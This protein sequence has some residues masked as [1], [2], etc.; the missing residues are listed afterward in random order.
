[1]TEVAHHATANTRGPN[2][3][4][5]ITPNPGKLVLTGNPSV[6]VTIYVQPVVVSGVKHTGFSTDQTT[7]YYGG[8][9]WQ[10]GPEYAMFMTFQYSTGIGEIT[11]AQPYAL[12]SGTPTLQ[13]MCL[14]PVAEQ[15]EYSFIVHY[16]DG[17]LHDPK[18]LV[19]PINGKGGARKRRTRS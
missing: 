6:P 5:D 3:T 4:G 13:T 7:Y 11:C 9:E 10:C 8:I 2:T 19:T 12:A 16:N 18:I 15:V 1:M 14:V 17:T